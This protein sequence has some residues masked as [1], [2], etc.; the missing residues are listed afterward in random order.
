MRIFLF[1]V[2]T[3]CV[4]SLS[5]AAG[6]GLYVEPYVGYETGELDYGSS[7]DDTKGMVYGFR[8]GMMS[9]SIGGGFDYGAGTVEVD[10]AVE[11]DFEIKDMGAYLVYNLGAARIWATYIFD[12]TGELDNNGD[13]YEKGTGLRLGVGF[14]VGSFSLNV[15][16]VDRTYERYN[17]AAANPEREMNALVF[18][19]S[20]ILP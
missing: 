4:S 17:N 18:S 19:A 15:E 16:K 3:L 9:G 11:D 14:P 12:A 1:A 6:D 8:L 7:D 13:E 10:S 2:L 5:R 20:I